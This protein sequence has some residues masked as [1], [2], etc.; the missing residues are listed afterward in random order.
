MTGART[1]DA[2]RQDIRQDEPPRGASPGL[3]IDVAGGPDDPG[4]TEAA[5]APPTRVGWGELFSGRNGIY[6]LMLAGGVG[7]HALNMNI[8]ATVMP[9]VVADIGGLD[10]YAWAT[11]L[12]V[13]ASIL[14]AA[15]TANLLR[16]LGPR[17]AYGAAAL[18]FAAGTLI[19]S[20][21]PTMSV[22]LVGRFLQGFGGGAFY[23]LAYAVTRI[24]FPAHLWPRAIGL[25]A[26]TFGI[27]TLFGPAVG[28][29]FAEMGIWRAA[30]WSLLPVAFG[31]A[32]LALVSLPGRSKGD[33]AEVRVAYPQ[34]VLIAGAVLA[35]SAGSLSQLPLWNFAG[36]L[37]AVLMLA[38]IALIE[39][40]ASARL[41]PRNSFRLNSP[42]GAIYL[43]IVL[44]MVSL[45]PEV[46]APYLLQILHGQS[47]LMAGY[48]TA[49]VSIGW[50]LGTLASGRMNARQEAGAF[51]AG[52]A[53]VF[54]G[55][56][57]FAVFMPILGGGDWRLLAPICLALVLIGL[58]I[59]ITWPSVVTL[60][61][62]TAPDD[63]RDLASGGMTTVQLFA[64]AFGTALAGMVANLAGIADPGGVTGASRAA[65]WIGVLFALP[66][67]ACIALALQIRRRAAT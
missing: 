59:G 64:F 27:T 5:A 55:L 32:A 11:T 4:R 8:V 26:A 49:L 30:F 24:V 12:F 65:L 66:P 39:R 9:S 22:M 47:P 1:E 44:L 21:A 19:A 16:R 3:A 60:V 36:F 46:Y 23:A 50:T 43:M 54:A 52:P 56:V 35:V 57:V 33:Q 40:R 34:L 29:I 38:A 53:I 51:L 18:L 62:R 63:E 41:L 45:Q 10:F 31:F 28:G 6:T 42:L 48:W 13:V 2:I 37:S 58:G 7:L 15:L 20:L 14:A 25:I 67:L 61:Y 17:G